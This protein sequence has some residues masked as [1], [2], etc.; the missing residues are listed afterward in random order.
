MGAIPAA[1]QDTRPG[2]P[3]DRVD[4]AHI[5]LYGYTRISKSAAARPGPGTI[6]RIFMNR[7]LWLLPALLAG[8]LAAQAPLTLGQALQ[9]AERS[10]YANRIAA[11]QSAAQ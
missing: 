11:G 10:A 6:M 5:L 7:M 1:C 2:G 8:P 9:R 4:A 3:G